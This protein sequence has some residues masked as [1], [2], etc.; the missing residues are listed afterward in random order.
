MSSA[1]VSTSPF[2][3][4]VVGPC[5][6]PAPELLLRGIAQF[7]ARQFYACHE[8]L[9][10]LWRAETRP[11]RALY[12]GILHIGVGCYHLQR[13]NRA[14][15]AGQLRR[16]IRQLSALPKVCQSVQVARLCAEARRCLQAVE[17]GTPGP[18]WFPRVEVA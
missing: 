8:T 3:T 14:G 4:G 11:V 7:N 5:A 16:G 17:A 18:T 15:A 9:E 10:T 2:E 13:G 6:E 12:Q 1:V